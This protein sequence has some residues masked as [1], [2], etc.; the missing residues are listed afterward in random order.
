MSSTI[1]HDY[2]RHVINAE[3]ND[4]EL[5]QRS[6][7]TKRDYYE[8]LFTQ[9]TDDTEYRLQ[10]EAC[11][12][13][14][15]QEFHDN[16]VDDLDD[17]LDD[18]LDD[19][20]SFSSED[21]KDEFE[22][23]NCFRIEDPNDIMMHNM[24]SMSNTS[25]DISS[26]HSSCTSTSHTGTLPS[27]SDNLSI[28]SNNSYD[29]IC[30]LQE[31]EIFECFH[32]ET[33][34]PMLHQEWEK[35][36]QEKENL[37]TNVDTI[38]THNVQNRYDH[39]LA[40]EMMIQ[41]N[42]T[43]LAIQEPHASHYKQRQGW[44][45]F[46]RK[47]LASAR[48]SA[49]ETQHQIIIYDN[50]KWGG[51]EISNFRSLQNGRI[52]AIAF[53][54]GR[55]QKIGII[56]IYSITDSTGTD[57]NQRKLINDTR[58]TT[59]FLVKKIMKEWKH[60]FQDIGIVIMGDLQETM[61]EDD[62][63][64]V[65]KC[66][67][68]KLK[69][70]LLKATEQSHTSIVRA[71]IG[72]ES[73]VTRFGSAGARGIDH[74]LV[75]N[76]KLK[77]NWFSDGRMNK[78]HI[79]KNFFPSDH[80]LLACNFER[81][82]D[83]N[84]TSS[85]A[86]KAYDYKKV[87]QIKLKQSEEDPDELV[88]DQSQ[89]KNSKSY[90]KQKEL[91][92]KIHKATGTNSDNSN[93]YLPAIEKR[94]TK[95]Y[96]SLWKN[97]TIQ[98]V[99]GA[100]NKLVQINEKQALQLSYA[101]KKF[102]ESIRAIMTNLDMEKENDAVAK[103]ALARK[104]L[105]E[106]KGFRQFQ[107]LPIPTKLRYLQKSIKNVMYKLVHYMNLIKRWSITNAQ[108]NA[109]EVDID[110][111]ILHK[112][113]DSNALMEEA[114][115]IRTEYFTEANERTEHMEA[116][117]FY[118]TRYSI[119]KG[120]DGKAILQ[121]TKKID[122][123][124]NHLELDDKLVKL[125]NHWLAEE[126]CH[127]AFNNQKNQDHF[128]FLEPIEISKWKPY[129][130]KWSEDTFNIKDTKSR[131][132][133]L[134]DLQQATDTLN[135][136]QQK[137]VLSQCS[138]KIQTLE[139]FIKTNKIERFTNKILPKCRDAPIP[140]STIWDRKKKEY[141]KCQNESEQIL[142]TS[143]HHSKWMSPSSA[144]ESCAFAEV[145]REG[146]LGPR[147]IK[148][149]SRR[150]VTHK[151]IPNLINKG[152]KLPLNIQ[153]RFIEAHNTHTASLFEEPDSD[154][155]EFSY[156][157]YLLND[158]G[159]IY[160]EDF[161]RGQFMKA[162]TKVPGKARH[163]GFQMAVLGRFGRRWREVLFNLIKIM[164]VMRYVPPDLKKISRFPIPKPGKVG[165]YRPISLC[166]DVY[167]FING[168]STIITS[169]GIEAAGILHEGIASYRKGMG[170]VTLVGV[171]QSFRE[172]CLES[173]TPAAQIDEDEEK[174]FDR[175]PLEIILAAMRVCGFPIQGFLELKAS[176]MDDKYVEI[177]TNKG[178]ARAMFSCGLEQG[179]PDS[180]TIANLV[181]LFKHRI[182][183][184]VCKEFLETREGIKSNAH[185]YTFEITDNKDG[186]LIIKMMGY[187]DD[188]SR[189]LSLIN[190]ED[191]IKLTKKYLKL[192][193]DLS[194]VTKIGRKGSKSE[195]HF[196]NLTSGTAAK[197]K[198]WE[199]VAWS[200]STDTPTKEFVPFKVS[201]QEEEEH[202]LLHLIHNDPEMSDE[203][204]A[205][206][207]QRVR[208]A[209][210]KHL[211]LYSDLK[212]NTRVTRTEVVKKIKKR[213]VDITSQKM[214]DNAQRLCNNML[215]TTV[216]SFAPIQSNHSSKQ[217][218][219]C[220]S[221]VAQCLRKKRGLANS[222][223]MHRF[224]IDEE[225]GGF[226]FKSFLEEDIIAV[227]RELEVVLNSNDLD[228]KAL[229]GRLAAHRR[230]P[231]S[232]H[233]NHVREAVMKLAKYGIY[234]RDTEDEIANIVLS[235]CA[236][237]TKF[238]PVGHAAYKDGGR[239]TIGVGKA[240]LL[241]LAMGGILE[242]LIHAIIKGATKKEIKEIC[243][244]KLPLS[245]E[246]IKKLIFQA[247]KLRFQEATKLYQFWEWRYSKTQKYPPKKIKDWELVDLGQRIKTLFPKSYLHM[248]TKEIEKRCE[249]MMKINLFDD[250]ESPGFKEAA[251]KL[252]DSESP[253][254]VA[255]DGSHINDLIGKF[256][257]TT[258]AFVACKLQADDNG[259]L[260]NAS[261]WEEKT[262]EPLI[263][264][265]MKLP[266][267]FGTEA[268]DISHGEGGA[269]WLQEASLGNVP[270]GVITDS[271]A[272]R[273]CI[274]KVRDRADQ[275]IDRNFIRNLSAGISKVI[276]GKFRTTYKRNIDQS[277]VHN[278]VN[279]HT[280]ELLNT[281]LQLR[282]AEFT[283]SAKEWTRI[284]ELDI[285]QKSDIHQH[286]WPLKYWEQHKSRPLFKV[287]SHQLNGTG[288]QI[289]DKPR[290]PNLVPNLAS[291]HANHVADTCAGLPLQVNTAAEDSKDEEQNTL[292]VAYS[293][294]RFF[295]AWN[296]LTMDKSI[297]PRL[298][299]IF[300]TEK[301]RKLRTKTTQG[302]LWRIMPQ[303][304][305][306]WGTIQRH[307]GWM[308]LLLGFSNTHTR[309]LYKSEAYRN[310]NWLE[311]HKD[312]PLQEVKQLE[313]ISK[314][315]K[316][317]WC[318]KQNIDSPKN[319]IGE[320]VKGN[321][322]HHLYFCANKKLSNFRDHMDNLLEQSLWN[323][324]SDLRAVI[325]MSSTENF[326]RQICMERR[327]MHT[328]NAGRLQKP[329]L[330]FPEIWDAGKWCEFAKTHTLQEGVKNHKIRYSEVFGF[331]TSS[332]ENELHDKFIGTGDAML[333]GIIPSSIHMLV[334]RACNIKNSGLPA[335]LEKETSTQLKQTWEKIQEI[336]IAK[337][338]GLHKLIGMISKDKVR[339][340][341]RHFGDELNLQ[342]FKSTKQ[343][344]RE[345]KLAAKRKSSGTMQG[346]TK[347]SK[348]MTER[349]SIMHQV[350]RGCTGITCRPQAQ[351]ILRQKRLKQNMI[352]QGKLQCQRCCN[353]QSAL[354]RGAHVLNQSSQES[355][356]QQEQVVEKLKSHTNGSPQ[357][358]SLMTMLSTKTDLNNGVK[359]TI[360]NKKPKISDQQKSICQV[361]ISEIEKPNIEQPGTNTLKKCAD[362]LLQIASRNAK[363]VR[364]T[365]KYERKLIDQSQKQQSKR[366]TREKAIDIDET[367]SDKQPE[368]PTSESIRKQK[369]LM[370][371][372]W[373]LY[374]GND[375]DK[376][377]E[378]T[379]AI[380]GQRIY[381]ADQDAMF[382]IEQFQ[383]TDEWPRFGRMFRSTGV[384]N[385]KPA[386]IYIIPLF[387]GNRT[388][389]HWTT[390]VIWRQGK[391]NRGFHLDSS[392]ASDT[393]GRVFDKIRKAF[394]GKKDRF[395]W[396]QTTCFPQQ[397]L[398]CGFRTVEAIRLISRA[399]NEGKDI[400]ECIRI[401]SMQD[402]RDGEYCPLRLR[403]QVADRW[404][405]Q[406]RSP[407]TAGG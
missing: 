175:I 376:D 209:E 398:E 238:A 341:K 123:H 236:R 210:H 390:V 148:L 324:I 5:S 352:V 310:G 81:L 222:D 334:T 91:L 325:G 373:Q 139:F 260:I 153:N 364:D 299:K 348:K 54:F 227:G 80:T 405:I 8:F 342:N 271:E 143:E 351:G 110:F 349:I 273:D 379:K 108:H 146:N 141:R 401:A 338:G 195:L 56:S 112:L 242:Q 163:D 33:L 165:E 255:T 191:L 270:R 160:D 178:N 159:K 264:R 204:K 380:A 169:K 74:I 154:R 185:Y 392:G 104:E 47:E 211:G 213:I 19:N 199:T 161:I 41:Q 291:L 17:N 263:A 40:A 83:N 256:S 354:K 138:Y 60:E 13:L 375:L 70:G 103:G 186:K 117:N 303:A 327:R 282:L 34:D 369:I 75:P 52:T 92:T 316:C 1:S 315:L 18:H 23:N 131:N 89:F 298:R 127:Q 51:K 346:D 200:F 177:I 58:N 381:F 4:P 24:E 367:K 181:I 149:K 50:W 395:S 105:N 25:M 239:A 37:Q 55:N 289:K 277:N 246:K 339:N 407:R 122:S 43:F 85:E 84:R 12:K 27:L 253:L 197:L 184:T 16:Q 32:G 241:Q 360:K 203:N 167:C 72:D 214:N 144:K 312:K 212:G 66:R 156:P 377:I 14:Q 194:M 111:A 355:S 274:I 6:F 290:Y 317:K 202:K 357:Y 152:S 196:Y 220:D 223:A 36:R 231:I 187:C 301:L 267:K 68:P 332:N 216:H 344:A 76:E 45:E 198:E 147:G 124:E 9:D 311:Y 309:S 96:K 308:R 304:H 388:Q 136:L 387:W 233:A 215:C 38:A 403:A 158:T 288:S 225:V 232:N 79:T 44:S 370:M 26:C 125:I 128:Q 269:I 142:A 382:L 207:E 118:D 333:L 188:N 286:I 179:N 278:K 305:T 29:S 296:G 226:G 258:A 193:G 219:E 243:P 323:F 100:K 378:N 30:F 293:G 371:T 28:S 88:L 366:G 174:F 208:P 190:E 57:E 67:K 237:M 318:S 101:T 109:S 265:V 20:L 132:L 182:W 391:R 39:V 359:A 294:Q 254:L 120:T 22:D 205:K 383:L 86:G 164:F 189:F 358:G 330:Q 98:H 61:T 2:L 115:T 386:G 102:N 365:A 201:L 340:W 272:V 402:R 251:M 362:N 393:R 224:W 374:S 347:K 266:T 170:C 283:K 78:D 119:Q 157:F 162:I 82:A 262:T 356:E 31:K 353:K 166:H 171:E 176:C 394:T 295:L 180:P 126:G 306:Q 319:N 275:N 280:E 95:L 297:A 116:I 130:L 363:E 404:E 217:L 134:A 97:G 259:S 343:A 173:G 69:N 107:H 35:C 384:E 73:Y 245:F 10:R 228:S 87:F 300:L 276:V 400:D 326:L 221:L 247:Q 244:G 313:K 168:V 302:L 150:K 307:K 129:L 172:D 249:E 106:G 234:L 140:H 406:R 99:N 397:E 114:K 248:N 331:V 93:H 94:I 229:R 335:T 63:D 15:T 218:L 322:I 137:A 279:R 113:L 192:T 368:Q 230:S 336:L 345:I 62:T 240:H 399:H 145:V 250:K 281:T 350:K 155:K 396:T 133:M 7:E 284:R 121:K 64:N 46:Q 135:A 329:P 361:I 90:R 65:G 21:S 59:T 287:N 252:V 257:H 49:F 320:P 183:N 261:S 77:R 385:S 328:G 372:K 337:I 42:I 285:A 48:L 3:D 53:E 235:Q 206:W 292:Q 389:G 314:S 268:T 11:E 151:D 321:R 71:M